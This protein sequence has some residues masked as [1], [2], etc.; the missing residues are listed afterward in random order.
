LFIIRLNRLSLAIPIL[1][2]I[3]K[4]SVSDDQM[5]EVSICFRP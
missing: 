3:R 2:S 4:L 1:K 5:L